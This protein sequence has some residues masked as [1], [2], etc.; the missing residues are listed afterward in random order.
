MLYLFFALLLYY[1]SNGDE[2]SLVSIIESENSRNDSGSGTVKLSSLI[3][4][5]GLSAADGEKF[6]RCVLI[7]TRFVV[8]IIMLLC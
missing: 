3:A 7:T 8:R 6:L 5:P 4:V 2:Y 1:V